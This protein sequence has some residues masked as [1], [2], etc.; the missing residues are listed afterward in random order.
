MINRGAGL[1]AVAKEAVPKDASKPVR[2]PSG[3]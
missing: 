3:A 2:A 1:P